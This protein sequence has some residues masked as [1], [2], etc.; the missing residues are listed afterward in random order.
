MSKKSKKTLKKSKNIHAKVSATPVK[1]EGMKTTTTTVAPNKTVDPIVEARNKRKE[2]RKAKAAERAE[3]TKARIK[4][5]NERK[6]A[7]LANMGGVKHVK[8]KGNENIKQKREAA[9]NTEL[10]RIIASAKRRCNRYGLNEEATQAII[11]KV[12][13][14][15]NAEKTYKV[16]ILCN[17]QNTQMLQARIKNDNLNVTLVGCVGWT[18]GVPKSN[19]DK[20]LVL[21]TDFPGTK[22]YCY[23]ES[24]ISPFVDL[25]GT[26]S[27][28]SNKKPSGNKDSDHIACTKNRN[29]NMYLYRR[30]KKAQQ[31][32]L[33]KAK[34][35]ILSAS[36]PRKKH[37]GTITPPKGE[38]PSKRKEMAST[39]TKQTA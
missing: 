26:K 6:S 2:E 33:N 13:D 11:E 10:N 24:R 18:K 37:R 27:L 32:E 9:T 14:N 35:A 8:L 17:A 34:E 3:R 30:W 19:L 31:Q 38:T 20:Y 21:Q 7:V 29:K 4:A 36:K 39:G 12:K 15:F 25:T 5:R 1:T 22:V 16:L 23:T 28:H